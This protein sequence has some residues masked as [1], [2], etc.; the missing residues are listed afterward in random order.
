MDVQ[1]LAEALVAAEPPS[2]ALG[3]AADALA[4]HGFELQQASAPA[5]NLIARRGAGGVVLS[6]HVDVVPAG[7]GWAR[8]PFGGTLEDGV[9]TARGASDMRG[10][11]A[12]MLAAAAATSEPCTVVLTSDEEVTMDTA[13]HL[14]ATEALRA[15]P[16]IVVG[17]PTELE[18]AS[19]SKGVLWVQIEL[20]GARAHASASMDESGPSAPERLLDLLDLL[21]GAPIRLDHP[22]LGPA[23]LRVTG[24]E[25]EPTPFNALAGWAKARVDCRF[26]P[27]AS[28]EDVE[29][30]V[31]SK[32]GLPVEG[33]ELTVHK[34]EPAFLVDDAVA[35]DVVA[36]LDGV[37]VGSR[38]T[39]VS[40]ASEAGHFQ[41]IA[42]TVICGP[43][44]IDRAHKPDEFIRA[45]ELEAGERAYA[46][47]IQAFAGPRRS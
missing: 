41:A 30:S 1:A 39:V 17:E 46:G 2:Q 32:L 7:E 15:P 31:H 44:S 10:P 20:T 21:D 12:C 9:L 13:R 25:S 29:R 35:E 28:S 27:P 42:P 18:V 8:E 33:V 34:R 45:S 4:S 19:A 16:L 43:G 22:E 3:V 14:V 26:P 24:M 36:A 11:V 23:T 38:R 37:G 47:L 6:G 40:F 5:P